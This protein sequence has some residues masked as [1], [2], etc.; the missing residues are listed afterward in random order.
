MGL[1]LYFQNTQI[2][3]TAELTNHMH[4][5]TDTGTHFIAHQH[6]HGYSGDEAIELFGKLTASEQVSQS[7]QLIFER[8]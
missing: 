6:L 3:L 4:P 5:R 2:L 1:P 8:I 7:S